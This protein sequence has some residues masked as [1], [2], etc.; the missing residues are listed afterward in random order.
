M[1]LLLVLQQPMRMS[2][3]L[4]YAAARSDVEKVILTGDLQGGSA[5]LPPNTEIVQILDGAGSSS[6]EAVYSRAVGRAER[7]AKGGSVLG[8]QVSRWVR[9]SEWR[10]RYADRLRLIVEHRR[11]T[12]EGRDYSAMVKAMNVIAETHEIDEIV[13]FDLFDLPPSLEF[14]DVCDATVKV[15]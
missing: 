11:G 3:A 12:E 10:L 7:W 1:S 2:Q 5:S 15:R 6:T 13:L 4:A 14:A 8:S 9:S